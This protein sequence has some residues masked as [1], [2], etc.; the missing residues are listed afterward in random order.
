MDFISN[1]HISDQFDQSDDD[2]D[3]DDDDSAYESD[4]RLAVAIPAT[5]SSS[6]VAPGGGDGGEVDR[7]FP[8][9]RGVRLPTPAPPPPRRHK[10]SQKQDKKKK[11]KAK[12]KGSSAQDGVASRLAAKPDGQEQMQRLQRLQR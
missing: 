10:S 4:D 9:K 8:G 7:L 12:K 1:D 5:G 3:D 11:T 2:D 6:G